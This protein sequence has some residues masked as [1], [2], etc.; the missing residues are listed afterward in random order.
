MYIAYSDVGNLLRF[1]AFFL[2]FGLFFFWIF[3]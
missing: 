1:I 2:N 3:F